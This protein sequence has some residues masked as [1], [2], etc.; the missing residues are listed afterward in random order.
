M[1]TLTAFPREDLASLIDWIAE[2]SSKKDGFK[3]SL[4]TLHPT[5]FEPIFN[6]AEHWIIIKSSLL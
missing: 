3:A 2:S 5:Q 1:G 6:T 4:M